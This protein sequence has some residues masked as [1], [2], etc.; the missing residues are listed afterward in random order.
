[1]ERYPACSGFARPDIARHGSPQEGILM[2][3]LDRLIESLVKWH[4][5]IPL[6]Y[7]LLNNIT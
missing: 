1:M 2:A 5:N 6:F 4:E 3:K 7:K